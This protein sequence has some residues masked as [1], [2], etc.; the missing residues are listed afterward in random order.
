MKPGDKVV[1]VDSSPCQTCHRQLSLVLGSVYVIADMWIDP[2]EGLLLV[3]VIGCK[4]ECHNPSSHCVRLG[5]DARRFRP[6]EE[7]KQRARERQKE[8][9]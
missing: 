8:T 7:F 6:L 4:D 5:Y 9:V 2:L 3:D 1:C